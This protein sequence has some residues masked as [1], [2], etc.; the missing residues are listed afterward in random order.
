MSK[1]APEE[2]KDAE[3]T[4][5]RNWN[6]SGIKVLPFSN[7][8]YKMQASKCLKKDNGERIVLNETVHVGQGLAYNILGIES[9]PEHGSIYPVHSLYIYKNNDPAAM[10]SHAMK[11]G[12]RILEVAPLTFPEETR[13]KQ[14]MVVIEKPPSGFGQGAGQTISQVLKIEERIFA[15]LFLSKIDPKDHSSYVKVK[16]SKNFFEIIQLVEKCKLLFGRFEY[17]DKWS[18]EQLKKLIPLET[19]SSASSR[20]LDFAFNSTNDMSDDSST[21]FWILEGSTE[22][23][24][25]NCALKLRMVNVVEI[26]GKIKLTKK[27]TINI[28]TKHISGPLQNFPYT[29]IAVCSNLGVVMLFGVEFNQSEGNKT[30]LLTFLMV[31]LT[32]Q[33]DPKMLETDQ[34]PNYYHRTIPIE[35]SDQK[36]RY[37]REDVANSKILVEEVFLEETEGI[38]EKY[39]SVFCNVQGYRTLVN[40]RAAVGNSSSKKTFKLEARTLQISPD[41]MDKQGVNFDKG[42]N[43]SPASISTIELDREAM[44]LELERIGQQNDKVFGLRD[45]PVELKKALIPTMS[46]L[47]IGWNN[48]QLIKFSAVESPSLMP[49]L[50]H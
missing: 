13:L 20:I 50:H 14:V 8:D 17:S 44:A 42:S 37:S 16:N 23:G 38:V 15:N 33:D 27:R 18:K 43:E 2:G 46:H 7:E 49:G 19:S 24:M 48:T 25:L 29:K 5:G 28:D 12:S 40:V 6:G 9:K 4:N 1:T 31:D 26:G 11:D 30:D 3:L 45:N 32:P 35:Q 21:H 47:I 34:D 10:L 39:F 41:L 36:I 22:P